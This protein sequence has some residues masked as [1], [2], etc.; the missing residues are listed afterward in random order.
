MKKTLKK[1]CACILSVLLIASA[2]ILP[3]NNMVTASAAEA[4]LPE[5]VDNSQSP[6]FPK[7]ESQGSV[8][9]C[10][11]WA[12]VYYSFTYAMNKSRGIVTTPENTYSP[13]WSFN[14]TSNGDGDGSTAA[15]IEYFLEK[16]GAVPLSMVPYTEDFVTWS[17]DPDVWRE[18]INNRLTDTIKYKN[19]GTKV[20][21]VTSPDDTDILDVKTALANGELLTFSTHINSWVATKLTTHKDAPENDKYV[22]EEVVTHQEGAEGGH[23]MTI[24]GYNDNIWTDINKNGNVDKGEMGAFKIANSW[25]DDYANDGFMWMAYDALNITTCVEGAENS[26]NRHRTV[27]GVEGVVVRPYGDGTDVYIRYNFSSDNRRQTSITITAEKDGTEY[28]YK[29]FFPLLTLVSG[30][31]SIPYDG[32]MLISLDNVISD[33]SA[34]NFADYNWSVTFTDK[35]ADGKKTTF[36]DAEIVIEST[37]QVFKPSNAYPI[38]LDGEQKTLQFAETKHNHA[39][40]YY[41]GYFAPEISYKAGSAQWVENVPMEDNIEREGYVNKAVIDLG[42]AQS[43]QVYFSDAN[44]N[45]D[46]NGDKYFTVTKGLNYFVTEGVAKPMEITLSADVDLNKLERCMYHTFS[47]DVIG[48]YAPYSYEYTLKNL[49]TGEESVSGDKQQNQTYGKIIN[50]TGKYSLSVKVTDYEGK[51]AEKS[52][53]LEVIDSPFEFAEFK[54]SNQGKIFLGDEV[55]FDAVTRFENIQRFGISHELYDLVIKKDGKVCFETVLKPEEVNHNKMTSTIAAVWTPA[56]AGHYTATI[57]GTDFGKEYAEASVQFDVLNQAHIYYRGYLNPTIGY[58]LAD[59]QWQTAQMEAC[60]DAGGYVNKFTLDLGDAQRAQI[61]FADS[62]GNTDNNSGSFYEV[63]AGESF[64]VTENATDALSVK[65]V[66]DRENAVRGESI[67]FKAAAQGGYAPYT[68]YY[69]VANVSTG[70][71]SSTDKAES[72]E[73]LVKTFDTEGIYKI[74]AYLTDFAGESAEDSIEINVTIPTEAPVTTTKP[75]EVTSTTT[76]P[77]EVT[78]TETVATVPTTAEETQPA[79]TT[80]QEIVTHPTEIITEVL[81]IIGDT[82]ADSKVN[83]KDATII[84]KHIANID[85][86]FELDTEIS[87]CDKDGKINIK[88]ATLIQKYL[89]KYETENVGEKLTVTT[90]VTLPIPTKA[91]TESQALT[92]ETAEKTE[93]T[94]TTV[95]TEPQETTV[96]TVATDPTEI[97]TDPTVPV[98]PTAPTK[99]PDM[100]TLPS[101]PTSEEIVETVT[102][103]PTETEPS[104]STEVVT[105]PVTEPE[106][107]PETEPVTEPK[108]NKVTFTNSFGWSG[109]V[110][111]Y[112]WSNSN[113][114]MTSWPGAPMTN[115]GTNDFGETLYTFEVPVGAEFIIFTNGAAQT[116]D[117]AYSGGEIRYYPTTDTNE[118]GHNK[119]ETW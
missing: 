8:G 22:D 13:Q 101:E 74:T 29:A 113:T 65:L 98:E 15:D 35:T 102:Q 67:T 107:E 109:T 58:K 72:F 110:S 49:T 62:N 48:G 42:D 60:L 111:C 99:D 6:Y 116:V 27:E 94:A 32:P 73:E 40:V 14:L 93:T 26:P 90:V 85:I 87:D 41:R 61:Y 64:F 25:G 117:I 89:A 7:I 17:T 70:E 9:A 21:L 53:E 63:K 103:A 45:T 97:K 4:E 44:G 92:T 59:G 76:E 50:T 68:C 84:Q 18:S 115:I 83:I 106:T 43:A 20:T 10:T 114:A 24:V 108:T 57:S 112:Y 69:S 12:H 19:F 119:V 3:A 51:I 2:F 100:G 77:T 54:V 82:N 28:T 96:S 104:V 30:D 33:I 16:Q 31:A 118:K 78:T 39:V 95:V 11:S 105:P 37:G 79:E 86:G 88:D 23:A 52:V 38:T 1:L 66:A 91:T 71:V 56:E 5:S 81:G 36:K 80:T 47:T 55:R 34:D 46:K 75:T